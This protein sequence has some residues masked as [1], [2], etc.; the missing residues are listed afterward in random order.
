LN[1]EPGSHY[2]AVVF[3]NG[4]PTAQ[5]GS[6]A[7]VVQEIGALVLI[8]IPGAVTEQA[9]LLSFSPDSQYFTDP[10]VNMSALVENTGGV[11]FSITGTITIYDIFGNA[12]KTVAI[13]SHNVLPGSKRL[14]TEGFDFEGFGYFNAKL[15]MNYSSGT[16]TLTGETRF[17]SLNVQRSIPI[18]LVI[19]IVGTVLI[20]FRKRI[21]KAVKIIVK[22]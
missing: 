3:S 10:K 14:F 17:T 15:V 1:A 11:H 12:V 13:T 8:K 4:S 5:T 6:V 19:I 18:T 7:N 22:G 2:G 16:K 21:V 20:V 9:S